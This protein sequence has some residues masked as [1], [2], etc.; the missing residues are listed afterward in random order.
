MLSKLLRDLSRAIT[1]F[2][3]SSVDNNGAKFGTGHPELHSCW[4]AHRCMQIK[5]SP[6]FHFNVICPLENAKIDPSE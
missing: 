1:I 6:P 4:G 3:H 5:I 2:L